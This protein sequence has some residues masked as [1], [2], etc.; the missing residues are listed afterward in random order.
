MAQFDYYDALSVARSASQADVKKAYRR[1]ARKFHPDVNP[2][3]KAAEDRFKR[4]Q[5]AYHVLGDEEK[6]KIYDRHGFYREG[7]KDQEAA[8]ASSNGP[9]GFSGFDFGEQTGNTSF[10]DIFSDLFS[11]MRSRGRQ[12]RPER[13]ADLEYRLSIPFLKALRGTQ[14][15]ITVTRQALCSQCGGKGSKSGG[16]TSSTCPRCGGK[17]E[18]VQSKGA[19]RFTTHC[20]DCGGTGSV[21]RGDCPA[22]GGM[23]TSPKTERINVRIPPGISSGERVKVPGKGNAGRFGGPAG[24]LVLRVEIEPHPFFD[25][26]GNDILCRVPLTFTE[27]ALGARIE[28]PTLDGKAVLTIPPGTQSGQ[29]LR[30]RGRGASS[31]GSPPGDQLVEIRI[32]V[33][34]IDDERSRRILEEFAHLHPEN[35]RDSLTAG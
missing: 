33:P 14:T 12:S 10:R 15:R 4:I 35:P 26:Q 13:G 24:D 18:V 27:A 22:C 32:V 5:E 17:G 3:D 29:K 34:R 11:G 30:M 28:V 31:K 23:G 1:L 25:R 2:G 16:K 6:R 8:W 9:G 20:P 19:L 21:R 7:I